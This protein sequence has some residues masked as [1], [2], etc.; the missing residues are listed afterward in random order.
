MMPKGNSDSDKGVKRAR[1]ETRQDP[2]GPS[3]H[4]PLCVFFFV[5]VFGLF[6]A[7]FESYENFQA[8]GRIGVISCWPTPQP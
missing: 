6:R 2:A 1:D 5:F 7:T 8:R 4:K 3:R